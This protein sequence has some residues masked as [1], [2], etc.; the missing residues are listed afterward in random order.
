ME[1]R[2]EKVLFRYEK[3]ESLLHHL[4]PVTKLVW[5]VIMSITILFIHSLLLL[6]AF[7]IVL[8]CEVKISGISL[9]KLFRQLKWIFIFTLLVIPIDVL[10]NAIPN[11]QTEIIFYLLPPELFP[12]RRIAVYLALRGTLWILA[13]ATSGIL[14]AITT[15]PKDL[16]YGLISIGIPYRFCFALM[17]GFRYIPRIQDE[18]VNI[19]IAQRLRGVELSR[20]RGFRHLFSSIKERLSTI[21]IAILRRAETTT[22]SMDKRGFGFAPKRINRTKIRFH[23]QDLLFLLVNVCIFTILLLYISNLLQLP[24]MPSIYHLLFG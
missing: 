14:F 10:F 9:Q 22:V 3:G 18:S 1:A 20:K 24:P 15:H 12:V 23:V 13:L 17:V 21:L 8:F 6:L 11:V 16:V 19:E 2:L 5:I 7:D 4:H